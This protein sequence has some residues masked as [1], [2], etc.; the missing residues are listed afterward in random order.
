MLIVMDGSDAMLTCSSC[1]TTLQT[2]SL[3][4]VEM[5]QCLA[6]GLPVSVRKGGGKAGDALAP[7][8]QLPGIDQDLLKKLRKRKINSLAGGR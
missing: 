6:Q 7:L 2:P 5:M 4:C 8:L 1:L 3:A